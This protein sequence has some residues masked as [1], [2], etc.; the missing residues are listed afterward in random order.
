MALV[1][2]QS[3]KP[4]PWRHIRARLRY[5]VL[6]PFFY[7]EW[8]SAWVAFF[9]SQWVLLELL[10]YCGT[11]SILI[12]VIFYFADSKSR[13]EQKHYQAWQVI[14]TA[15]GKGGSGGRIDALEE[16]NADGVP[17][18]GV[19][20][21]DA[22]LQGI[23]LHKANLLRCRLS[24]ADARGASFKDADLEE[25]NLDYTNL[26]EAD[27][28]NA[29]LGGDNLNNVDLSGADLSGADLSDVTLD[30]ADLSNANLY[31][32]KNWQSIA[33]IKS[34]NLANLRN[35]PDGFL[36]WGTAHGATATGV[37][38]SQRASAAT[39]SAP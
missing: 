22:F 3:H 31:G 24:S 1:L 25:S 13:L 23:K 27:L 12:G 4:E 18:V 14:N 37:T 33:S 20:L 28:R 8:L 26:R 21:S 34:A 32:V 38:P 36:T 16:L 19:D 10:E 29:K 30:N 2:K 9:M 35:P 5:R 17:L 6:I 7:F 11:L 39:T 15:Q